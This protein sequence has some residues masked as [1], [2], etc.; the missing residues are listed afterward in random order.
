M[1]RCATPAVY[2]EGIKAIP[3][4]SIDKFELD[5]ALFQDDRRLNIEVDGERYHRN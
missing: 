2:A 4:Y 1:L 5:F 3:Q